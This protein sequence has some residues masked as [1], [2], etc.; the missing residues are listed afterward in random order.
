MEFHRLAQ[1][2]IPT[3][4]LVGNHDRY[5][6]ADGSAS[7]GIYRTLAVPNFIVGDRLDLHSI[8]T[9]NGTVQVITLPWL[10][11][12]TLLTRPES[13]GSPSPKSTNC[14]PNAYASP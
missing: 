1:A 13:Q 11:S 5:S 6:L 9:R 14:W 8:P 3:V 4:L 2:N 10:T 7:L 12:S